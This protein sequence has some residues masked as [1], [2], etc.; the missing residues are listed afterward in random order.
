MTVVNDGNEDRYVTVAVERAGETVFVDSRTVRGGTSRQFD[1]VVSEAGGYRVVVDTAGGAR[2]RFDWQVTEAFG[3]L[4]VDVGETVT[5]SRVVRCDPDCHGVSLGGSATGYPNGGF[6]PRGRRA[7]S[8]LRVRNDA[9]EARRVRVRVAGGA[10]LDYRYRVPPTTTLTIPVPQRSGETRVD[11]E[12]L[13]GEG[14]ETYQWSME[15]SPVLHALV[16]TAPRFTCGERTRDVR[17]HNEDDVSHTVRIEVTGS[18]G[19][20][21][22]TESYDLAPGETV[23]EEAVVST[24]GDYGLALVTEESSANYEWSTCPPRGPVYV[25]VQADGTVAA[26]VVVPV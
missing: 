20:R 7:G 2:G 25:I 10:V 18:E 23:R 5:F 6:D 14:N 15:T 8:R 4:Q 11:V 13:D 17:L 22:F 9:S 16:G 3:D 19:E 24:A 1:G 26:T 21:L 12:R